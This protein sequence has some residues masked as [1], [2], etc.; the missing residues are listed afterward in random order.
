MARRLLVFLLAGVLWAQQEKP[1]PAEPVE[2]P[3]EDES[4]KEKEYAF[5]PIQAQKEFTVG[6]FYFKKGS[7]KAAALRY[8]EAVKWNPG[9]ADAYLKLAAAKEKQGLKPEAREAYKA[10]LE[11]APDDKR[12]PEIRKKLSAAKP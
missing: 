6:N 7:Y 4:L 3:E 8:E 1:K 12:A 11:N 9:F 10:F 2:P 5:N